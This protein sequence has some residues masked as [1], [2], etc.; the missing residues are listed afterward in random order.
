MPCG[1]VK[2]SGVGRERPRYKIEEMTE[3]RLLVINTEVRWRPGFRIRVADSA[4]PVAPH[5]PS[6]CVPLIA[7]GAFGPC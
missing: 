2:H 1:G 5:I 6:S 4:A 3:P 7:M